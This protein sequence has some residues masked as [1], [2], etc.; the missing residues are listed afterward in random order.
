LPTALHVIS[1]VDFLGLADWS[2]CARPLARVLADPD[3]Q[4]D[5]GACASPGAAGDFGPLAARLLHAHEV[6]LGYWRR[7]EQ[8]REPP[9]APRAA[10]FTLAGPPGSNRSG[11]SGGGGNDSSTSTSS[12]T[13]SSSS[14]SFG[15]GNGYAQAPPPSAH[16][17]YTT[18]APNGDLHMERTGDRVLRLPRPLKKL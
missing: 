14:S 7:K 6:V 10:A 17:H 1:S 11:I 12:T 18:A 16:D 4:C 9:A 2:S 8:P 5:A 3:L 13:S 15:S